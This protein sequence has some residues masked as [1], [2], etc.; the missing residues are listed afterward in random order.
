MRLVWDLIQSVAC[1]GNS[2]AD[3]APD[4]TPTRRAAPL[5]MRAGSYGKDNQGRRLLLDEKQIE[6]RN[7]VA[8]KINSITC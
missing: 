1:R 2:C 4:F 5:D 6:A 7:D 3:F 8:N